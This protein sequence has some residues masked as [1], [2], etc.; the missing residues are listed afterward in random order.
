MAKPGDIVRS[1]F[2]VVYEVMEYNHVTNCYRIHLI[3]DDNNYN[4]WIEADGI[5]DWDLFR[6]VN[7]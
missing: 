3:G 2:G 7:K 1:E 6:K 5:D 4:I